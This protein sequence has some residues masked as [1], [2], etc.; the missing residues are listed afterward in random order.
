MEWGGG[1]GGDR[2]P[3]FINFVFWSAIFVGWW[4]VVLWSRKSIFCVLFKDGRR[5]VSKRFHLFVSVVN[6]RNEEAE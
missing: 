1:G 6:P 5:R 3:N 2:R 4:V